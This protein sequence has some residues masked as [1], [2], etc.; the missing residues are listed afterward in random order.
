MEQ[1]T[2][3]NLVKNSALAAL[4]LAALTA[5]VVWVLMRLRRRKK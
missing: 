3:W 1:F 2:F 5:P 4:A